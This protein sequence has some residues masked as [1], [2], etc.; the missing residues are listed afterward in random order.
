MQWLSGKQLR[1]TGSSGDL[2]LF[3]L[4]KKSFFLIHLFGLNNLK[5]VNSKHCIF[6]RFASFLSRK[7][8]NLQSLLNII[9]LYGFNLVQ[10]KTYN[11]ML[12]VGLFIVNLYLRQNSELCWVSLVIFIKTSKNVCFIS[13]ILYRSLCKSFGEESIIS[14][15]TWEGPA[16]YDGKLRGKNTF[17]HQLQDVA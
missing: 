9:G 16:R 15:T 13:E 14:I 17:M 4:W 10:L 11:L 12:Q 8:S 7:F 6:D 1:A 3:K 5:N 2:I